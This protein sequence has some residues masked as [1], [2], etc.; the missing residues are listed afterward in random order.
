MDVAVVDPRS[1]TRWV[2]GTF[3]YDG[4]IVADTFWDKLVPLGLQ[5]GAD[6]WT[7]PAVPRAESKPL[8][9]TVLNPGVTLF[10]H[11]GCEGRLAGPVDNPMSS[12]VS[13]H[14]SAYALPVGEAG[15]MGA[16]LPPSFGFPGACT[17]YS[18][19][20]AIYFQNTALPEAY[21]G[22]QYPAALPLDTSL[23]L[24]VAL[25]DYGYFNTN[26]APQACTSQ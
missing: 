1:P 6:P 18:D 24:E 14:A 7:F 16:T 8:R 12:C 11:E 10:E 20:N 17:E 26:G 15:V 22:G 3:V 19:D 2:Y 25:T 23:Q 13:C 9:Q 5:W 21:Q 4:N